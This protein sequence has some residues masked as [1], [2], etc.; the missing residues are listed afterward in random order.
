MDKLFMEKV[1]EI[2]ARGIVFVSAVGND[3]PVFGSISNPADHPAVIGVG[4]INSALR[5]A[6][7]SSRGVTTSEFPGKLLNSSFN[8]DF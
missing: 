1:E 7:F 6:S 3:G 8:V 2:I 5:L 4:A